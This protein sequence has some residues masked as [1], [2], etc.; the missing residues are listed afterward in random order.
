[1]KHNMT[2]LIS[3]ALRRE[4]GK[5]VVHMTVAVR[6]QIKLWRIKLWR[7]KLWRIKLWLDAQGATRLD[8]DTLPLID[9]E[10]AARYDEAH[11][12]AVM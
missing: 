4:G 5:L 7:I 9:P 12:D 8:A 2:S 10:V 11:P 6:W 3:K 1:M